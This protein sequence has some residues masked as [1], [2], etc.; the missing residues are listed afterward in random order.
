MGSKYKPD[1]RPDVDP[2]VTDRCC[3][4]TTGCEWDGTLRDVVTEPIYVQKVY[5]AIS[6]VL[7][8]LSGHGP[9]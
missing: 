9:L 6:C 2:D 8:L 1:C 4:A 7:S 5:D 3:N